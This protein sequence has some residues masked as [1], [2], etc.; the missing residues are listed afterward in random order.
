MRRRHL[1]AVCRIEGQ[2]YAR[3][4][5]LPLFMSELNLRTN[6]AYFVARVD[7]AVV[8]YA[9]AMFIGSEAHITNVA[10]DPL[11]H[12]QRIATRLLLQLVKA[13][14]AAG[15]EALTLEVRLSS[16]GAQELYRQ[17]GFVGS[18][19]RKNYYSEA[20]EDALVMWAYRIG[21]ED[22]ARRLDA[23]QARLPPGTVFDS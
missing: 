1:R 7:G 19:I 10:V 2:V 6:R 4:W 22:Y 23:I 9:G 18:G 14:L 17:F 5:S 3:P 15:A 21:S 12:R 20:N 16:A 11:W 13:S 8:G